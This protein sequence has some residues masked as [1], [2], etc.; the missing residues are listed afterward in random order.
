VAAA[1]VVV[2]GIFQPWMVFESARCDD[3]DDRKSREGPG[4]EV[5]EDEGLNVGD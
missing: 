2:V 3:D 1:A 5:V 4:E